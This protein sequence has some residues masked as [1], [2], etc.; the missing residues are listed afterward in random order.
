[1]VS[2][3]QSAVF[4]P[5]SKPAARPPTDY[6]YFAPDCLHPSQKLHSLM[7]RAL[8]NNMLSPQGRKATNWSR[9]PPLLCPTVNQPY[10]R[11]RLNSQRNNTVQTTDYENYM[12]DV[13][14]H[15]IRC[16]M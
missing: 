14:Q 3:N 13:M 6:S 9:D 12:N 2:S 1:M 8:W 7:A 4:R 15:N 10:L 16:Y 5:P 11:T